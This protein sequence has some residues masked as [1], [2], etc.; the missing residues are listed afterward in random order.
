MAD[1]KISQLPNAST[2]LAGTEVLPIVQA[3]VTDQVTVDNL[4]AGR[5]VPAA[6]V[7]VT[8][9]TAPANGLYLPAANTVGL[10]TN[11][12]QNLA[13]NATGTVTMGGPLATPAV[14]VVPVASQAR[15]LT[16]TGA[17][18][19]TDPSIGASGG[20]VGVSASLAVTGGASTAADVATSR[21][22]L[23]N[24]GTTIGVSW[25]DSSQ[26]ANGRVAEFTYSGGT[27]LLRYIN[28]AYTVGAGVL[29]ATGTSA[30]TTLVSLCQS[31]SGN[32]AFKVAPIATMNRWITAN[33][34]SGATNARLDANVGIVQL[35]GWGTGIVTNAAA[36]YT[37]LA[38]DGTI[39]QTT[40]GSTYTLPAASTNVGRILNLVTQFAGAVISASSNVVPIAGGAAGTAILAA[41]AGKYAILQSNGT[42]WVI[43]AAN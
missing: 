29:T 27:I 12:A 19:S 17:T 37:V 1:L 42:N 22:Q 14:K 38:T 41:T 26:A 21:T 20:K 32:Y 13:V 3:G 16:L 23:W 10:S 40:A 5:S 33:G 15:W 7:V 9:S 35:G 39:I 4:T 43:I 24:N 6:S 31:D 34:G 30:G 36:T 18:A 8:G 25:V 2:P 28:D 11:S